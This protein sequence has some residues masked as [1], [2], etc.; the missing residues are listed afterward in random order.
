MRRMPTPGSSLKDDEFPTA[1][2][3]YTDAKVYKITADEL[4]KRITG[5]KLEAGAV[6][7]FS[8]IM[9]ASISAEFPSRRS[10]ICKTS[11]SA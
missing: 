9:A 11:A 8:R 4:M 6:Y 3:D 5:G 1:A 10:T 7:E 2:R